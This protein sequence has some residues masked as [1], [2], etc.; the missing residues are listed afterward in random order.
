MRVRTKHTHVVHFGTLHAGMGRWFRSALLVELYI[1]CPDIL[2]GRDIRSSAL[3]LAKSAHIISMITC[4]PHAQTGVLKSTP[5]TCGRQTCRPIIPVFKLIR[6]RGVDR[7]CSSCGLRLPA[8]PPMYICT[9]DE[10]IHSI[11]TVSWPA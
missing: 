2:R 9:V 6:V 10:M 7:G 5:P 4:D 1:L 8:M 3:D 11:W